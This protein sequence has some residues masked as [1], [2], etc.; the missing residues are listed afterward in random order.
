MAIQP[1]QRQPQQGTAPQGMPPQMSGGMPQPQPQQIASPQGMPNQGGQPPMPP[2]AGAQIP[3]N[4][5]F[6]NMSPAEQEQILSKIFQFMLAQ[7]ISQMSDE[8]LEELDR[9]ITPESVT[10]L[11]KLLPEMIPI[12][13]N[14]S[15][16]NGNTGMEPE[17]GYSEEG[18]DEGD[19]KRNPLT[20]DNMGKEE[21]KMAMNPNVS[22]GLVR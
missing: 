3:D 12:F 9:V 21:D 18:E 22:R 17:E 10:I 19:M 6:E 2:Q 4:M 20:E 13:E 1:Y 8:E 14:A 15:A 7:R 5:D 16:L 11:S